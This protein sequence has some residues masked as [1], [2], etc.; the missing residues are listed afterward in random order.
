MA[1]HGAAVECRRLVTRV[2][3]AQQ[4]KHE[5]S[6]EDKAENDETEPQV[7]GIAGA[8]LCVTVHQRLIILSLCRIHQRDSSNVDSAVIVIFLETRHHLLLHNSVAIDVRNCAFKTTTSSD[9]NLALSLGRV[10]RLGFDENDHAI[11][12]ATGSHAPFVS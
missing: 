12:M 11:V 8:T 2:Y 6:T 3:V 1:A 10:A 4:R 7:A 5:D 9:E